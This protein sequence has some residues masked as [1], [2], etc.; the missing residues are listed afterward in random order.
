MTPTRKSCVVAFPKECNCATFPLTNATINATAPQPISLKA[1]AAKVLARNQPCNRDATNTKQPCNF[2]SKDTPQKLHSLDHCNHDE[3]AL[4]SWC[5]ADCLGMESIDLPNEGG[6]AGC[7]HP[8][9]GTWRRLDWLTECPATQRTHTRPTL[10]SWCNSKCEHY[11]RLELPVTGEMQWC[12]WEMD[13]KNWQR[14]RI[15]MMTG[16]PMRKE[17]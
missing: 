7:V 5:R 14:S 3:A 17:N 8:I 2:L 13:E 15:D 10:P 9:T 1:L 6:T 12:C 11:H 4:P 16:C